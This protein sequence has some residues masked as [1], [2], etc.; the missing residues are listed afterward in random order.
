[1]EGTARRG[2]PLDQTLDRPGLHSPTTRHR[3]LRPRRR[4]PFCLKQR[5]REG[6]RWM[7]E[8]MHAPSV[9][10]W[11]GADGALGRD[12]GP[13]ELHCGL[14]DVVALLGSELSVLSC[15]VLLCTLDE[16]CL[17]ATATCYRTLLPRGDKPLDF[18]LF[19][20]ALDETGFLTAGF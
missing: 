15:S 10:R 4:V 13:Q 19:L 9:D 14:G 8:M 18:A 5:W 11:R 20:A 1:M 12:A 2:L 16:A 6:L 7:G 3:A 17:R